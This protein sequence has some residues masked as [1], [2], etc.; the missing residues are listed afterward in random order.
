[1]FLELFLLKP[2][3]PSLLCSFTLSVQLCGSE[4]S[5]HV[6]QNLA[7]WLPGFCLPGFQGEI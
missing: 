1:M 7:L 4:G 5:F 2:S 6:W 3:P